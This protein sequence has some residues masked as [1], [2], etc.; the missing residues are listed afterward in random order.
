M[1]NTTLRTRLQLRHD[2]KANWDAN[3]SVV[4]LAGE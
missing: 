2:T 4:L 1:A 3:R